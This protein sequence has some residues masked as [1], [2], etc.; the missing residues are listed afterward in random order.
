MISYNVYKLHGIC[1]KVQC[2]SYNTRFLSSK[3]KF[4]P[5]I[6]PR[7]V[8]RC[9]NGPL[10]L[11]IISIINIYIHLTNFAL[12]L[13]LIND[14]SPAYHQLCQ[15]IILSSSMTNHKNINKLI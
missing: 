10:D 6:H 9:S 15:Q 5:G 2:Q 11:F 13:Y 8:K 1:V 14:Y 7:S 12:Q 4:V 3:M